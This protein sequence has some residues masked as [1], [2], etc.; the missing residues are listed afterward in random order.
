MSL[1]LLI[2]DRQARAGDRKWALPRDVGRFY[3]T[4]F[5][6]PSKKSTHAISLPAIALARTASAE[7]YSNNTNVG[8]IRCVPGG[9]QLDSIGI[10]RYEMRSEQGC[11]V[12][13]HPRLH[14]E[15]MFPTE[16][17]LQE[18]QVQWKVYY[19]SKIAVLD[20]ICPA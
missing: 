6:Q 13:D 16:I 1:S 11:F 14:E 12:N 17:T 8:E 7:I 18:H 9:V 2:T 20:A 5:N 3:D 10:Q 19:G 4:T 15:V